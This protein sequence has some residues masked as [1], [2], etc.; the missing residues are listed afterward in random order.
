M[1]RS[2]GEAAGVRFKANFHAAAMAE[3]VEQV[4]RR[5]LQD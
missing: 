1:R 4:Y 3:K 2:M 5:A